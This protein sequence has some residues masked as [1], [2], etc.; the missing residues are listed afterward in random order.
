MNYHRE[1]AAAATL[2]GY[3]YIAGG[4]SNEHGNET[5]VTSSV[6]LYDPKNDDWTKVAPMNKGRC[7]F[8]LVASNGF[9]YAMGHDAIVE[10]FDPYKNCWT[11]VYELNGEE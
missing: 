10:R 8:A 11:M 3:I 4:M 2:N 1:L 9:L 6:D 7:G 5:K